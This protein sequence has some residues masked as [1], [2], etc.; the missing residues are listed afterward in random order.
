[1]RPG[2]SAA[3]RRLASLW[4]LPALLGW[5]LAW[6]VFRGALFLGWPAMAAAG[7]ATAARRGG[8][9]ARRQHRMAPGL[10]RRRF[11]GFAA[12]LRHRRPAPAPSAGCW[13]RCC[14]CCS[15]RC[16]A[17]ATRRCF[18]PRPARSTACPRHIGLAPGARVVD[19]GCGLGAGLVALRRCFPSARLEG[20]DW[21][22][23]L[24][25]GLPAALSRRDGAARRHLARRLVRLPAGLPVPAPGEHAARGRRRPRASCAAGAW[26]VSL[27]FPAPGLQPTAQ[28]RTGPGQAGLALPRAVRR[29]RRGAGL[30]GQ[31]G[32]AAP[33][34][35]P[36]AR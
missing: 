21:S 27:E 7:C 2:W 19:A 6:A 36:S 31:P 30:T 24:V 17:G 22:W 14:C 29:S 16:A 23:P 5:S 34:P 18:R 3:D 33:P 20:L 12:R 10:H 26:L 15:I 25:I 11:S 35:V 8:G 13:P 32:R 1:M 28:H 4:P 9:A